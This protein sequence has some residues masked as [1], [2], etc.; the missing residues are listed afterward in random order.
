MFGDMQSGVCA[1]E[2]RSSIAAKP[3][4]GVLRNSRGGG[5]DSLPQLNDRTSVNCDQISLRV[6]APAI[7]YRSKI[8]VERPAVGALFSFVFGARPLE[9]HAAGVVADRPDLGY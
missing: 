6:D 5:V 3:R 7:A 4:S 1:A 8:V 9:V 2:P